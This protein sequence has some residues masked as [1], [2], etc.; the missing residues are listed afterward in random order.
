M[1]SQVRIYRNPSAARQDDKDECVYRIACSH[2]PRNMRLPAY[3]VGCHDPCFEPPFQTPFLL[4]A[5][6]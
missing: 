3:C 4:G 1:R 2:N 6:A 5:A